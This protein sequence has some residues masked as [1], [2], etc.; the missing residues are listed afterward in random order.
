MKD[1]RFASYHFPEDLEIALVKK[2]FL[3]IQNILIKI[4]GSKNQ[5]KKNN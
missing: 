2:Y 1:I 3:M 4:D 5:Q